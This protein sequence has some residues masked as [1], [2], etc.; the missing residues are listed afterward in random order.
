[1]NNEC[2]IEELDTRMREAR[3]IGRLKY[4]FHGFPFLI[5]LNTATYVHT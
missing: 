4:T 3:R 1:M 2:E 5:R